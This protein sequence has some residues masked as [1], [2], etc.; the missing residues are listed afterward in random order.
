MVEW[1]YDDMYAFYD[2]GAGDVPGLVA[3][4]N[5]YYA[6]ATT[7]DPFIG[8]CCFGPDARVRGGE[9]DD[10]P[11]DIGVGLRP[12]VTGRGLGAEV[13]GAVLDFARAEFA[14]PGFRAT[15]ASFN[16]RALRAAE[17]AGFRR[18]ASFAGTTTHGEHEF[19]LLTREA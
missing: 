7:D 9:Y 2:P 14:P 8:Y 6:M 13:I 11:L 4:E 16:G 10:G 18:S 1:R 17:K 15:I 5:R 3:P 12:D 19:V